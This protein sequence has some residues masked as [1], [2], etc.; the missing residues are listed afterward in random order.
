MFIQVY[1]AVLRMCNA[2]T[3]LVSAGCVLFT[4]WQATF[5]CDVTRKVCAFIDIGSEDNC[6][7]LKGRRTEKEN[8]GTII[9]KLAKFMETCL[10]DWLKY[11]DDKRDDHYLLNF[12][13]IDQMVFLQKQLALMSDEFDPSDLIYPLLYTVKHDCT[14]RDLIRA[15]KKAKVDVFD[16]EAEQKIGVNEKN[17]E[18]S[19]ASAEEGLKTAESIT[20]FISEIKLAGFSEELAKEALKN[21]VD[22]EDVDEGTSLHFIRTFKLLQFYFKQGPKREEVSVYH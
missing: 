21:D 10:E 12:F 5:L 4:N 9:P 15:L 14:K 1:D 2:Y 11:I 7:I 8:L 22:P 16:K 18:E 13:T 17:G 3:K 19:N 20:N 6:T